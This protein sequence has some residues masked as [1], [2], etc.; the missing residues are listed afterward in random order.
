MTFVYPG[1]FD[2]VTNGHIDIIERASKLCDK[3]LVVVLINSAKVPSFTLEERVDLLQCALS[4]I[5][6]V[7]VD[8]YSGLL[9]DYMRMK[10]AKVIVKGLRAV[11]DFEYE[12][13]MA[14]FHKTQEP[15]IETLFMTSSLKYSFLSSSLIKELARNGGK[16]NDFVPECIRE[17]I[18]NKL[19]GTGGAK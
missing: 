19:R 3:V 18:L 11:S 9:V 14:L 2:P 7:E 15:D 12:M 10:N 13:Q 4:G 8:S 6:N 17:K 5:P 16:I 1:S